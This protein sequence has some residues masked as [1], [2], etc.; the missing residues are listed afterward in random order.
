[1]KQA[2]ASSPSHLHSAEDTHSVDVPSASLPSVSSPSTPS[3]L[4]PSHSTAARGRR[5]KGLVG[6]KA[7]RGGLK[8][9]KAQRKQGPAGVQTVR[10]PSSVASIAPAGA[11][12]ISTQ[13]PPSNAAATPCEG[14]DG[15]GSVREEVASNCSTLNGHTP[16]RHPEGVAAT[17]SEAN[18]EHAVDITRPWSINEMAIFWN[19][20]YAS[21]RGFIDQDQVKL[22]LSA[23]VSMSETKWL[24]DIRKPARRV[25]EIGIQDSAPDAFRLVFER[26]V[27]PPKARGEQ[28][29]RDFQSAETIDATIKR[30]QASLLLVLEPET[31][32]IIVPEAF[33]GAALSGKCTALE[34]LSLGDVVVYRGDLP[35]ADAPYK[36]GNIRIQG[37]INGVYHDEGVV[38]RV[39]WA[40]YRCIHCSKQCVDKRDM[41]NHTRFCSAPRSLQ[42]LVRESG[43]A[44]REPTASAGGTG[45]GEQEEKDE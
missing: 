6:A 4:T 12:A 29:H 42:L 35:H 41:N 14:T 17:P 9:G 18:S 7:G 43:I 40:V 39:V 44:T 31:K 37:L 23:I 21:L 33:A 25:A 28:L 27:T 22:L 8:A 11:L 1:M 26:F 20:G 13:D 15:A 32:L 10:V 5:D 19:N 30:V 16:D 2:A 3:H 24:R 36:D 34:D 45:D 38:E